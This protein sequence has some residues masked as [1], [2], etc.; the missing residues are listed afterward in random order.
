M[1]DKMAA[2]S[3]IW[4]ILI[5]TQI[6]TTQRQMTSVNLCFLYDVIRGGNT[7]KL[8]MQYYDLW[9][10]WQHMRTSSPIISNDFRSRLEF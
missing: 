2:E 1:A 4:I 3:Q 7:Q 8:K 5:S 9:H 6:A 10:D